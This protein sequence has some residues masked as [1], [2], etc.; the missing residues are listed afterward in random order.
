[1]EL[2][3]NTLELN[4]IKAYG[5][6]LI[7]AFGWALST[8]LTKIY[9]ETVSPYY[10]LVGRFFVG[11]FFI[12]AMRPRL[13]K[14]INKEML[15]VGIPL[16]V[17]I[18][19]V[20]FFGVLCLKYTTA[21]KSG[22]LVA[23]S[24][25]FVPITESIV[26]KKAPSP[27]IIIS[28]FMSVIGLRLISGM[29]GAGFNRGDAMAITSSVIYTFYILIM[30]RYGKGIDDMTLTFVQLGVV[31]VCFSILL[32][33]L[34]GF[35]FEYIKLAWKPIL[36]IGIFCTGISTLCQTRAQ[37]IA[38]TESVGVLLLGEPLF[39]FIMAILILNEKVSVNGVIGGGFILM[40][41]VLA[42][43]KDI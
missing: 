25:L 38:S 34:E 41:L 23:L 24:V 18:F 15:K 28:V 36:I 17:L 9:M 30:D 20:Y 35:V 16:G 39:T 10:V 14:N 12:L 2:D 6:L 43:I 21:S 31:A 7:T 22:F 27:W 32:I 26:G 3:T 33:I 42:V 1:M 37:K 8:I 4:K 19:G 11:C 29:D 40:S 5:E 13:V